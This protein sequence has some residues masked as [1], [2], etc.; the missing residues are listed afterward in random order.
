MTRIDRARY[1]GSLAA[2][3]LALSVFAPMLSL[4]SGTYSA[5]FG[6]EV[7]ALYFALA[8]GAALASLWRAFWVAAYLG[9][10][11]FANGLL[12]LTLTYRGLHDGQ[13]QAWLGPGWGFV[14]L[15]AAG[16]ALLTLPVWARTPKEPANRPSA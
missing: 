3:L 10:F 14:L 4:R 9:A 11:A 8:V 6:T 7:R 12:L 2:C 1:L 5:S 16:A 13:M 15:L